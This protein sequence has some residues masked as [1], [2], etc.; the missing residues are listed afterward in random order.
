MQ[1]QFQ[2]NVEENDLIRIL[3]FLTFLTIFV[4]WEDFKH[5][6]FRILVSQLDSVA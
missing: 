3:D 4:A 2:F 5:D 6:P 1:I